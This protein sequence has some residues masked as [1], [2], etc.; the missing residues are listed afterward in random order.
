ML[1]I[2]ELSKQYDWVKPITPEE[3]SIVLID[4][5][6][7]CL[8]LQ[9]SF[10]NSISTV[11]EV[12]SAVFGFF[13]D[14]DSKR[15]IEALNEGILDFGK[16]ENQLILNIFASWL[17]KQFYD[18]REFK[19]FVRSEQ[20]LGTLIELKQ[21]ESKVQYLSYAF[22]ISVAVLLVSIFTSLL[23]S[24]SL[25]PTGGVFLNAFVVA[26]AIGVGYHW[27]KLIKRYKVL[28]EQLIR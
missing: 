1:T 16:A 8:D 26:I 9:T 21:I 15:M 10:K 2:A 3:E 6:S 5:G 24:V 19:M 11:E 18:I 7:Y 23:F 17:K 14:I 27:N 25:Q 28:E 22:Y 4:I 13:D 12:A 20:V